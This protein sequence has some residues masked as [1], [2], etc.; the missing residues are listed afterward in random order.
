MVAG[1]LDSQSEFLKSDEARMAIMDS[2]HR[3]QSMSMIHQK[4]YQTE[5]M[6]TIDI[7]AYVHEM[8]AYL[9]DSF[10]S[11]QSIIFNLHIERV[12]MNISYSIPLGLILNEAIINSI[13]YAFPGN[14]DGIITIIL[15]QI[16]PENFVLTIADNGIGLNNDFDIEKNGTFGLALIQGLCDDIDGKLQIKNQEGTEIRITFIYQPEG[17]AESIV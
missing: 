8:V 11:P 10:G 17:Q 4:L 9:K 13:K 7:S 3:I 2:Q 5:N 14:R 15:E 1:L 16:A 12:E 6:S